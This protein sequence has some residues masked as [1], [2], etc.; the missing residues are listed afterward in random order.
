L[1]HVEP[2]VVIEFTSPV[3]VVIL[4]G[5]EIERVAAAYQRSVLRS[6]ERLG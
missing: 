2:A 6:Q 4:R 1:H 3:D 5:D